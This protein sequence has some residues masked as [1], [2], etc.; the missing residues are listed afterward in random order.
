M[1]LFKEAGCDVFREEVQ[2]GLP[3]GLYEVRSWALS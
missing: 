1:L 3:A 2:K